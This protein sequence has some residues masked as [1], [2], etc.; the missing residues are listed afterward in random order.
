MLSSVGF[1]VLWF[2]AMTQMLRGALI[3]EVGWVLRA[4]FF[5]LLPIAPA[6]HLLL[7]LSASPPPLISN[8]LGIFHDYF[9]FSRL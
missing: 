5:P 3:F 1:F 8:L 4:L 9:P 2:L 6:Q 7:H